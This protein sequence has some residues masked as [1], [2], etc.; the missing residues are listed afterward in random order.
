MS[1][2]A[3]AP[4]IRYL[5][6]GD[7]DTELRTIA[8]EVKRLVLTE[9]YTLADIGLVVRQRATYGPVI[10]RVLLEE[11]IPCNLEL[12]VDAGDV[13]AIAPRSSCWYCSKAFRLTSRRRRAS[14]KSRI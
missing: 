5:E 13:P 12:R 7:R 3:R 4:E 14:L 11:E 2:D 9:N 8:R 10:T 6:C 1:A